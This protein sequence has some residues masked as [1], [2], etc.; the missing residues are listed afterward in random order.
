MDSLPAELLKQN[1]NNQGEMGPAFFGSAI[2]LLEVYSK[3]IIR[4]VHTRRCV[5]RCFISINNRGKYS[6][7]AYQGD[8]VEFIHL[9]I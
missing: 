2:L 3:E 8:L 9:E 1:K 4:D 6:L 5:Y 7:S